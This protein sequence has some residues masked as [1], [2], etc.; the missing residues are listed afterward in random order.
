MK[1]NMSLDPASIQKAIDKLTEYRDKGLQK[2]ID[3]TISEVSDRIIQTANTAYST[4]YRTSAER[5]LSPTVT[6]TVARIVQSKSHSVWIISAFMQDPEESISFLEF[7]TGNKVDT[8]HPYAK[9][10]PYPVYPGSWSEDET[11]GK[12]TYKQWMDTGAYSRPDGSYMYDHRPKRG[13][14]L[15]VT[16]GRE[17][18]RR[19][20]IDSSWE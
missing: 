10:V 8:A 18:L 17:Y 5:E 6:F 3:K 11:Y 20:R 19:I 16:A 9:V 7:G 13:M 4:T 12:G 1:L 14:Y 15:G 2:K